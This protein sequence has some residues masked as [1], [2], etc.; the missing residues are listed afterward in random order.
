MNT[1]D[2]E[3]RWPDVWKRIIEGYG[4]HIDTLKEMLAEQEELNK[5]GYGDPLDGF[6]SAALQ[7]VEVE[8]KALWEAQ[9]RYDAVGL[10]QCFERTMQSFRWYAEADLS[11]SAVWERYEPEFYQWIKD[12]ERYLEFGR[13]DPEMFINYTT[14]RWTL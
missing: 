1:G 6:V 3:E 7:A 10:S 4:R 11:W 2:N 9:K 14:Y 12:I 8:N 5:H 13:R